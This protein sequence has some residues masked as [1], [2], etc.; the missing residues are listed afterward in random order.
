MKLEPFSRD[1]LST[2]APL[3]VSQERL[4]RF[5]DVDAAGVVFY[6]R[7]FEYFHDATVEW[8]RALGEPLERAIAERRWGAPIQWCEGQFIRPM[9]FGDPIRTSI[10]A[11]RIEGSEL[12]LGFRTAHADGR[13]AAI[14]QTREVFVDL[15]TFQR[16]PA[17]STLAERL[18]AL[19]AALP[20]T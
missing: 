14:G 18:S 15:A 1:L 5:Q 2:A 4:V 6:P 12:L 7:I 10:V 13:V 11:A 17:P 8:L 19:T 20:A 3:G 9:R 16:I